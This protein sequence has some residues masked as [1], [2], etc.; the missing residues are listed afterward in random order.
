[1]GLSLDEAKRAHCR[2]SRYQE[3]PQ[4]SPAQRFNLLP[5]TSILPHSQLAEESTDIFSQQFPLYLACSPGPLNNPDCFAKK[6][7]LWEITAHEYITISHHV[8]G[9]SDLLRTPERRGG[10][11]E[12]APSVFIEEALRALFPEGRV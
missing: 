8:N 10:I 11:D 3:R 5:L 4:T 2:L 6:S 1:M 7:N 9:K 12:D